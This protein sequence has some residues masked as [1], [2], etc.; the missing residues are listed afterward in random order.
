MA[1]LELS[2][3]TEEAVIRNEIAAF[4]MLGA[5]HGNTH[6]CPLNRAIPLPTNGMKRS[7]LVME[8]AVG[9]PM[10]SQGKSPGA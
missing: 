10:I 7:F 4:P 2:D 8:V 9:A 6:P 1:H 5:A 3:F